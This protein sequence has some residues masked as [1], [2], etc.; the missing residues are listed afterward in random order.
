MSEPPPPV[1]PGG[2]GGLESPR[3][4]RRAVDEA[5]RRVQL[6]MAEAAAGRPRQRP[7]AFVIPLVLALFA[8]GFALRVAV[9]DPGALIANMYAAPI[10]ILAAFYGIRGG[11]AG[12]AFAFFLVFLWGEVTATHIDLLGYSTRGAVFLLVGGVVG[13][14]AERLPRAAERGRGAEY[15]LILRNEELERTN[16]YL[17]QSVMRFEA[18]TEIARAV[19]GETD[20]RRVLELIAG[21]GREVAEARALIVMLRDGPDL[22][23]VAST[24]SGREGMRVPAQRSVA[25]E[26]LRDGRTLLV[27]G[28]TLEL[29]EAAAVISPLSFRGDR[30][31]VLAVVDRLGDD[32]PTFDEEDYDLVES[33]AASAATAV[34]TA[35]SIARDRLRDTM[36]A[37][38]EARRRWARELHDETLQ[39]LG[40]LRVL[41]SSALRT[42]S[43]DTLRDAVTEAV[44]QTKVEIDSLRNLITELR[45][46]ALDEL[47][48]E[49]ALE[50]LAER[51]AGHG[52][53]VETKFAL[54]SEQRLAPELESTI[55]R[56]VQE[57]L[58]NVAKHA[59]ADRVRVEVE[60]TNGTVTV[61]VEDDGTGFDPDQPGSGLGLVGMRERIEL[62]GGAL[63]IDSRPAGPT[64]VRAT[65]PA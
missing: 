40:G 51:S 27:E 6:D 12:A 35:Q 59:D 1:G 44:E 21:R 65:V 64:R 10:A 48:L 54:P 22:V 3:L 24:E 41:L 38:E 60:R 46:A 32:G 45:P 49:P 5:K 7:P 13:W 19:G 28:E 36:A 50:H 14:Y 47:G 25:G 53:S 39:G 18:F 17:A 23:V 52:L 33:I 57:A 16:A 58:T 30:F 62:A 61:L 4:R 29:G 63:T 42:G 8:G 34:I 15:E 2:S 31:G 37:D 43:D 11:L 56:V 55:Y 26:V 9:E 20:P